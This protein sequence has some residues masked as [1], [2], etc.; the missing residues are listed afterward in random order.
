LTE[1]LAERIASRDQV[2]ASPELTE[3]MSAVVSLLPSRQR[4]V[5]LLIEGLQFTAVETAALLEMSEGA[6]K[7]LL[8]RARTKLDA[9]R[10]ERVGGRRLRN[11]RMPASRS[12]RTDEA[13]VYA[14]LDAFRTRNVTGLLLLLNADESQ[15]VLPAVQGVHA[16]PKQARAGLEIRSSYTG[17]LD[18]LMYAA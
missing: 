3:A 17:G 16:A 12:N 8:H 11:T 6:V 1:Q 2:G 15:D 13:V 9:W 5:L 14:Y 10:Q 4:V 18:V 7:A